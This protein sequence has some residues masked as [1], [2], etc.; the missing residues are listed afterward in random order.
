MNILIS[1]FLQISRSGRDYSWWTLGD[2]GRLV[3]G[4]G[5]A[6]G[7][8][9]NTT[10]EIKMDGRRNLHLHKSDNIP[11]AGCKAGM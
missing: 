9:P 2:P 11:Y 8:T 6:S 10:Q 5:K 4:D 7:R 3:A 1:I